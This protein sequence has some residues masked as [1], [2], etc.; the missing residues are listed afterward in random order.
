MEVATRVG[1]SIELNLDEQKAL[2]DALKKHNVYMLQKW[3]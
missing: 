2:Q 1:Q 3:Q